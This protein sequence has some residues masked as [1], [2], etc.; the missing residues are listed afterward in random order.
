MFLRVFLNA[1][2]VSYGFSPPYKVI[3][4]GSERA[5][6]CLWA[7]TY[8]GSAD[9]AVSLDCSL[10]RGQLCSAISLCLLLLAPTRACLNERM[11]SSRSWD[12]NLGLLSSARAISTPSPC[13]RPLSPREALVTQPQKHVAKAGQANLESFLCLPFPFP[14]AK[15]KHES[16]SAP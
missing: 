11:D 2:W 9:P 12:L 3:S 5:G 1:A 14:E 7:V 16:S 6:T 15:E 4:P 8:T 13:R 10:S